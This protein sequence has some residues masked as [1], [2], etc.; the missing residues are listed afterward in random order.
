MQYIRTTEFL[1]GEKGKKEV[2]L[3]EVASKLTSVSFLSAILIVPFLERFLC[4]KN[5]GIISKIN[6]IIKIQK[7]FRKKGEKELL[8]GEKTPN[9]EN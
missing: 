7:E 2:P 3:G 5:H 8:S 1:L 4:T 6:F 9:I